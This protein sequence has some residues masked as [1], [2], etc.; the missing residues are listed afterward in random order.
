[1]AN[2]RIGKSE[3]I[4]LDVIGSPEIGYLS[5]F[6]SHKNIGFEIKSIHYTYGVPIGIKRGAHA[7]K[8]RREILWCPYGSI[9]VNIDNGFE[10]I[11]YM[12]DSPN[13][14]L[15]VANR[16]WLDLIWVGEGSVLCS[17]A[18]DYYDENDYIRDYDQFLQYVRED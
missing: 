14:A 8:E 1:M 7:H 15:F 12:L 13:K 4:T 11:Y 10:K 18:S 5:F 9:R 2:D 16:C 6:E 17:A 3:L